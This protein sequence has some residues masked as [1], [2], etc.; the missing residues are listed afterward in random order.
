VKV[1]RKLDGTTDYIGKEAVV[2]LNQEGKI[3]T[4]WST[5]SSAHR[6]P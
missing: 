4:V 2:V 1:V 3:V 5:T 6:L